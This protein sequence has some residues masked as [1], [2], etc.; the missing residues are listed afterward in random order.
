MM[1]L[2]RSFSKNRLTKYFTDFQSLLLQTVVGTLITI[3]M[4]QEKM[5]IEDKAPLEVHI[6]LPNGEESLTASTNTSLGKFINKKADYYSKRDR[7][8]KSIAFP[9]SKK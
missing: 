8:M 7:S 4:E 9:C 3:L 6:N 1:T 2:R 5:K